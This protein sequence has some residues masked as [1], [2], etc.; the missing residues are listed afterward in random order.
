MTAQI[1]CKEYRHAQEV[2]VDLGIE[3][4][5]STPQSVGDQFWFWN[6]KNIPKEL[7]EYLEILDIDPMDY[8]GFGL[9][10][11]EAEKIRDGMKD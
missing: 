5:Y 11:D 4:Q 10:Q 9:D 6:C 3:Y 2:M 8:I 7:P 1:D